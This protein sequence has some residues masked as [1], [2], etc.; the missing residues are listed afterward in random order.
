M[1]SEIVSNPNR[2]DPI[3][4]KDGLPTKQTIEWF[5]DLE[6][7]I[8][9]IIILLG[10][11]TFFGPDGAVP[12][13]LISFDGPTG[14]QGKDSGIA[15]EDVVQGPPTAEDGNIVLFDAATGKLIKDS[16]VKIPSLGGGDFI[17]PD[18]ANEDNFVSFGNTTGKLGKDSGKKASD[19]GDVSSTGSAD[20]GNLAEFDATSK[21]IRDSGVSTDDVA[22]GA[23]TVTVANRVVAFLDTFGKKLKDTGILFTNLVLGPG[24]N[25]NNRLALFTGT[26][27]TIK[28]SSI[29]ESQVVTPSSTDT[30]TNKT[31]NANG[32]GN[33]LSNIDIG[34]S[35]AASQAEAEAGT[36]N[37]K[38]LTSLR[39]KQAITAQAAPGFRGALVYRTSD[40]SI[41]NNTLVELLFN[42]EKYDTDNI[43][44]NSVNTQRLTVPSGV[45]RVIIRGAV[46]WGTNTS[47]DRN[48]AI[49]FNDN[50]NYVGVGQY[51]IRAANALSTVACLNTPVLEVSGN[52]YFKL[53]VFQNSGGTRNV[54]GSANNATWFSMEIIK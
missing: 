22:I 36:D 32:T 10:S 39:V 50:F 24:A 49:S 40:Q 54:L 11:G 21:L 12:D 27:N 31:Y 25:T 1:V 53:E 52:Q 4:S 20:P 15:S 41:N 46:Y 34:N 7:R 9:E 6:L 30:F 47:G 16:G 8:N 33:N 45:T 14:K 37:S 26:S 17:G 5:D 48:A 29:L 42:A 2:S 43:H 3:V 35:I 44:N 18:G 51:A 38:L 23:T 28:Q 19:F 13:N